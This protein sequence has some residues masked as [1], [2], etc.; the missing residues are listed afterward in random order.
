M[1]STEAGKV[2][3]RS[4]HGVEANAIIVIYNHNGTIPLNLRADAVQADGEGSWEETI[5]AYP[6]DV[7][8]ITQEFGTTR[9]APTT[10]R[11]PQP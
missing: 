10:F 4:T 2:T 5:V 9:S 6:G 11:I 1:S 8:D 7:V 3:L